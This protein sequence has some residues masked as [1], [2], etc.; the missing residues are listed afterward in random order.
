[1][2]RIRIFLLIAALA[3]GAATGCS[4]HVYAS[5]VPP[6]PPPPYAERARV[7]PPG[8]GYVWVEGYWLRRGNHWH[9]VR[10][11]WTRP[12]HWRDRRW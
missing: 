9:W 3:A 7:R 4:R 12:E 2:N 5:R 10:G 1:M 11:Y 8:P 6:P